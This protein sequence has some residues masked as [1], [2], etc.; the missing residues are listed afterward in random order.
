MKTEISI[1]RNLCLI[2]LAIVFTAGMAQEQE[3]LITKR[4]SLITDFDKMS[5]TELFVVNNFGNINI[6]SWKEN[7][8]EMKIMVEVTGWEEE[9]V[10]IFIEQV[11]PNPYYKNNFVIS[12]YNSKH[13]KNS[14]CPDV[15]KVYRPWFGKNAEVKQFRIDYEIKIPKSLEYLQLLNAYGNISLPSYAGKLIIN[16]RNGNLKTGNLDIESCEYPGIKVRYG[17]VNLGKVNNGTLNLYSCDLVKIASLHNSDLSTSFSNVDIG[18]VSDVNLQSK[19][20]AYVIKQLDSLNGNGQFTTLS[21]ANLGSY[22]KFNNRSGEINIDKISPSFKNIFLGGQFNHYT[23]QV[24]GLN[25]LFSA[26]LESTE[27][28]CPE[29]ICSKS[30][31]N[32]ALNSSITFNKKIGLHTSFSK[33]TLECSKCNIDMVID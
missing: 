9:E 1:F 22:L 11:F 31:K 16:L 26:K 28:V 4:K 2:A 17:K 27:L 5:I 3:S 29:S 21:I 23:M 24:A 13:I 30:F 14:C 18:Y 12:S 15:K 33:I 20:D 7:Y 8:I 32:E 10:G 25:Y 19:S 6:S